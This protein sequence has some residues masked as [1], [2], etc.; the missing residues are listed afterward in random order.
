MLHEFHGDLL[1]SRMCAIGFD[2][3]KVVKGGVEADVPLLI[4]IDVESYKDFADK[5]NYFGQTLDALLEGFASRLSLIFAYVCAKLE[6][7]DVSCH[8]LVYFE[9][10][11]FV[12][13]ATMGTNASSG[14]GLAAD[15]AE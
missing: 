15:S 8:F 11:L 14:D 12:D 3:V 4:V 5:R 7:Y 10:L 9:V 13:S 1:M 2:I 6:H